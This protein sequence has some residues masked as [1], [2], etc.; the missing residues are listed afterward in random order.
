MSTCSRLNLNIATIPQWHTCGTCR[1]KVT[2]GCLIL[3]LI[4]ADLTMLICYIGRYIFGNYLVDG[5]MYT[6]IAQCVFGPTV[7]DH[8]PTPKLPGATRPL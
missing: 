6:V 2:L 5:F 3:W 8:W 4:R 1:M 7:L